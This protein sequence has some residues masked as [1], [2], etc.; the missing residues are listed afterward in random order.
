MIHQWSCSRL[1]PPL[2]FTYLC[3]PVLCVPVLFVLV[4][5]VWWGGVGEL[6]SVSGEELLF[7]PS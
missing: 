2:P 3:P 7:G 4:V 6:S 1:R 5:M